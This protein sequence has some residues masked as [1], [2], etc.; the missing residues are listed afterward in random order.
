VNLR[1]AHVEVDR[2]LG[3]GR[4]NGRA[5]GF[6]VSDL[7]GCLC[8][9]CG[10]IARRPSGF[11]TLFF[12]C[13]VPFNAL[14]SPGDKVMSRPDVSEHTLGLWLLHFKRRLIKELIMGAP[15]VSFNQLLRR[16][17]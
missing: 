14:G 1:W 16:L 4:R 15:V 2:Q 6:E 9:L 8:V 17:P 10:S 12:G 7:H 11:N 5:Y 3:I 13:R